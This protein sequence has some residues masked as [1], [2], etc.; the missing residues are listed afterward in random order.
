MSVMLRSGCR[1]DDTLAAVADLEAGTPAEAELRRWRKRHSAGHGAFAAIAEGSA[2]FPPFFVW[3]VSSAGEDLASGL[4]RAAGVYDRRACYRTEV[5]LY[6]ALPLAILVIGVVI[7]GEAWVF[8][9]ALT[10]IQKAIYR[11]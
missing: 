6:A 1:L 11:F 2:V 7:L 5:M 4:T 3:V 8:A 10:G 9:K